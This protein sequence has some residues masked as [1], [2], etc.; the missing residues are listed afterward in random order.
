MKGR[1]LLNVVVGQGAAVFE[2]FAGEDQALLVRRNALLVLDLG[3]DVVDGI[4]G[5][6]LESDGLA[7]DCRRVVSMLAELVARVGEGL[8]GRRNLRVLTK[9][10]MLA[11]QSVFCDV[12][13]FGE[14]DELS[15][16]REDM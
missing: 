12:K 7:G 4:G 11:I 6:D 15:V 9:I 10:C 8:D 14:D 1:L 13:M 2:L 5:L 3:F 16:I